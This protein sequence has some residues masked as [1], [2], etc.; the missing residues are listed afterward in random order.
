[1]SLPAPPSRESMLQLL[2]PLVGLQGPFTIAVNQ[3]GRYFPK[4]PSSLAAFYASQFR[5]FAHSPFLVYE[6]ERLSYAETWIAAKKLASL[7]RTRFH[8]VPGDRVAIGMRNYP[9]WCIAF[10]ACGALG[11]VAVPLNSFW[12]GKEMAY[13]L[14]DSGSKLLFCDGER[15][16]QV[17]PFLPTLGLSAIVARSR[18]PVTEREHVVS[19]A[20]LQQEMN[21][22]NEP[23]DS[24]ILPNTLQKDDAAIIM[25]TSGT[26]GNPKGVVLTQLGV[27][28]QMEA[29]RLLILLQEKVSELPGMP[30]IPAVDQHCVLAIVPFFHVTGL[31]H[32]FLTSLIMGRKLVLMF[33]W[34]AQQA[35]R[36]IQQ[37]RVTQWTGVPTMVLDIMEH[38]SFK[39]YDT[40]SLLS[41]GSGGAAPPAPMAKR[42]AQTFKNGRGTN[43]YGLTETNGAICLNS[44]LTFLHKPTSCGSPFPIVE[45]KVVD[46]ETGATLGPNQRGELLVR[47][48]LVMKEYWNKPEATAEVITSDGFFRTGDIATLDEDGFIYIVDRA[49]DIIIRGGENISCSEVENALYAHPAIR[50]CAVFGLPHERLG[51]EVG[52]M[53]LLKQKATAEELV[54]FLQDKLAPFKIPPIYNIFFTPEALPRGATGKILKR[55]IRDQVQK[56]AK[57]PSRL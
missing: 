39:E 40:S 31:H 41:I 22:M 18:A 20:S 27:T 15:F 37:E 44:A 16:K 38:P 29:A 24:S 12:N 43:A 10:I 57:L 32:L 56:N 52:V 42:I 30:S 46:T 28:T 50:E 3:R 8:V 47:S 9:E 14:Q 26:T 19:Y 21:A 36:L 5:E 45:V 13:G 7:M 2:M 33:K 51:E 17:E 25:Y 34:D 4:G 6:E 53:I 48:N 23:S 1:M 35:L 54:V 55:S 11:A 49:K